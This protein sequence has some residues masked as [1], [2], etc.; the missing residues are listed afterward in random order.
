MLVELTPYVIEWYLKAF[1][2]VRVAVRHFVGLEEDLHNILRR[3][4]CL[5]TWKRISA[6]GPH[7]IIGRVRLIRHKDLVRFPVTWGTF[8]VRINIHKGQS[9]F[10]KWKSLN[11]LQWHNTTIYN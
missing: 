3:S 9:Y 1:M 4:E 11:G 10:L 7:Y 5:V 6:P 8:L 2:N